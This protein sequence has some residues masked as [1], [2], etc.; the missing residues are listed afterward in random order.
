MISMSS[1]SRR[2]PADSWRRAPVTNPVEFGLSSSTN[3]S[4]H[5]YARKVNAPGV[6]LMLAKSGRRNWHV[7]SRPLRRMTVQTGSTG[8]ATIADG[9]TRSDTFVFVLG[10]GDYAHPM[11]LNG[12]AMDGYDIAVLP[13]GTS[14]VLTS[15]GPHKWISFSVTPAALEEADFSPVQMCALRAVAALIRVPRALARRLADRATDLVDPVQG[16]S[17]SLS[18]DR[19]DDVERALLGELSAGIHGDDTSTD[20][21][22]FMSSCS[23]DHIGHEALALLRTEDGLDL[24]VEQLC[25]TIDVAER[26]LLRAFHKV[27]GVGPTRYMKLRR[28]NKVH[29]ELQSSDC[30]KATV[31][32]VMTACGV[33]EFGRF[34]GAYRALFSES[35]SE[36]LRR[37]RETAGCAE[38][39]A[40]VTSVVQAR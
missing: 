38:S 19:S 33:T 20:S 34:A 8:A 6:N 10:S 4:F 18:V 28:L 21:A 17:N 5:D 13:P 24:R 36:T 16:A 22:R 3:L 2:A 14:F 26:S 7:A 32:E 9:M 35:P 29:H 30:K 15:S 1:L 31:T 37:K 11:S 23:L 25:R 39:D 12:R 27:C 40:K